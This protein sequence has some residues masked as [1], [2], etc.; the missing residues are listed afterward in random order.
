MQTSVHWATR[1][2]K[3]RE[4]LAAHDAVSCTEGQSIEDFTRDRR[5]QLSVLK[6]VEIVGEAVAQVSKD[7][8][9]VHLDIPWREIVGLRNRLAQ[10]Y[11]DIDLPL[12]WDTVRHD[13]PA[14][15]DRLEPP[16]PPEAG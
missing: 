14:L 10:V 16:V 6:S 12:I 13:L 2:I 9:R 5:T 3:D 8:R 4:L 1:S 15:N 11:F 7:T